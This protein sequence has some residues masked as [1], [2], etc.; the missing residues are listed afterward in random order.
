MEV[1]FE[2]G[3]LHCT[4][5]SVIIVVVSFSPAHRCA[6]HVSLA[7]IVSMRIPPAQAGLMPACLFFFDIHG[8]DGQTVKQRHFIACGSL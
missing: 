4:G 6:I 8:R 3:G 5:I 1:F 7:S 2:N